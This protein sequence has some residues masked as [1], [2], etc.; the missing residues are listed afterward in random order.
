[1]YNFES[2]RK[3]NL[4]ENPNSSTSNQFYRSIIR[5]VTPLYG[6]IDNLSHFN[7]MPNRSQIRNSFFPFHLNPT[8]ACSRIDN[9]LIPS[10]LNQINPPSW[11]IKNE[12]PMDD[13]LTH[14]NLLN[15]T[16]EILKDNST[17]IN[18]QSPALLYAPENPVSIT[19]S[20]LYRS[21][22]NESTSTSA[23]KLDLQRLVENDSTSTSALKLDLHRLVENDS[24]LTSAMK[25]D[26]HRLV[27]ND[28]TS[29]S[30]MKL[31]LYRLV[32]NDSTSTSVVSITMQESNPEL[33]YMNFCSSLETNKVML[34]DCVIKIENDTFSC[35][36][37]END[38]N[39]A[40]YCDMPLISRKQKAKY[41]KPYQFIDPE[42]F[43]TISNVVVENV[44]SLKDNEKI[45]ND[46]HF[47]EKNLC[48]RF[49]K[50]TYKCSFCS[51][52]FNLKVILNAHILR[53]HKTKRFQCHNCLRNFNSKTEC[54]VHFITT[55][56]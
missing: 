23:M 27:D 37:S 15:S 47:Y 9:S 33:N 26:L 42:S 25:R 40:G 50:N 36:K 52:F 5:N 8:P 4:G 3:I 38:I 35:S 30:D 44:F 20:N 54:K 16:S 39:N 17:E 56:M 19:S 10:H 53:D 24:A 49:S 7:H 51:K 41:S 31:D 22:E 29:T 45:S 13:S 43:D 34:P 1:M 14:R 55:H 32:E 46:C 21:T 48:S 6:Y 28:S 11:E 12:I 2:I 18:L